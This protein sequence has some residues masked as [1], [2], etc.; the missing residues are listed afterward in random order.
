MRQ[1]IARMIAGTDVASAKPASSRHR[2]ETIQAETKYLSEL[3]SWNDLMQ[4]GAGTTAMSPEVA[5]QHTSVYACVRL[6]TG[7][8]GM[9]PFLTYELAENGERERLTG[10][11]ADLLS[12][13]PN[14]RHSATM[15]WRSIVASMLL[16]GNGYAWIE[17]DRSGKVVALHFVPRERVYPKIIKD[18]PLKGRLVY[19]LVL[20]DGADKNADQDDVLHFPGT[21]ELTAD[22]IE[23]KSP[24]QA[25]AE[26]VNIGQAANRHAAL[27]FK[28]AAVP[29]GYISYPVGKKIDSRDQAKEII[30]YW[31]G[32]VG[33]ENKGRTGILTEGGEFKQ[34]TISAADAQLLE[35]RK[36]QG[37]DVCR[38]FGVPPHMV[39]F[40]GNTSNY[41]TGIEEQT[42]GFLTFTLGGHLSAIEKEVNW[43]LFRLSRPRIFAEFERRALVSTNIEKRFAAYRTALGGS[44]GPGF[45]AVDE[46]RKRENMPALGGVYA[47]P[48]KWKPTAA[49]SASSEGGSKD[50]DDP[51]KPKEGENNG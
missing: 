17:R 29:P 6:I 46:V 13:R 24:I 27:H 31:H 49:T 37:E 28:N 11:E 39:G 16:R 26:A 44:S 42:N 7:A 32:E 51:D 35:S 40:S 1:A 47:K 34:L 48:Q 50:D 12:D 5:M 30:D 25:Y 10:F 43:K 15:F 18:G 45:M 4:F 3:N 22:G 8:C 41:G 20:D 38:V 9:L 23:A 19:K 2:T 21:S 33:G 14:A 36:F